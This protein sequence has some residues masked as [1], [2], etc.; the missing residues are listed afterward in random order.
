LDRIN[1][2]QY[3]ITEFFDLNEY[4]KVERF[5][6]FGAHKRIP[7]LETSVIA[8]TILGK[9]KTKSIISIL[10]TGGVV[11]VKFK[12][13]QF[14]QYDKQVSE[15]QQD[16]TKKILERSWFNKG[17]KLLLTG[18]RNGSQFVPKSYAHTSTDILYLIESVDSEGNLS[19]KKER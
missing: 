17:K 12:P 14:A 15:K 5:L 16:G 8:G 19:L 18:F 3:G 10:T 13:E 7:V 1:F 2:S 4:P 11:Y 9:N 6:N